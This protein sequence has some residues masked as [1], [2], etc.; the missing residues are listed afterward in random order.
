MDVQSCHWLPL[1]ATGYHYMP[2]VLVFPV[3]GDVTIL[4]HKNKMNVV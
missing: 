4:T 2:V 3:F 1:H